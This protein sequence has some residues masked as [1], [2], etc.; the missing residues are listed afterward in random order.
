MVQGSRVRRCGGSIPGSEFGFA[1]G[2]AFGFE[3]NSNLTANA[4]NPNGE[5]EA[6]LRPPAPPNRGFMK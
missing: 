6:N 3:A 2:F 5:R 4:T 1:F